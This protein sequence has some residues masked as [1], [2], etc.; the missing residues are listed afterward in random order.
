MF[1][2]NTLMYICEVDLNGIF[3]FGG[4]SIVVRLGEPPRN[5]DRWS[6]CFRV[7]SRLIKQRVLSSGRWPY[8]AFVT[9]G[10]I[11]D[12]TTPAFVRADKI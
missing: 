7:C 12:K 9:D 3:I 1:E 6:K 4:S 2:Y 10:D 5:S 8:N 11:N